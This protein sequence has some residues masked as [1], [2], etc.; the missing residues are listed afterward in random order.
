MYLWSFLK[1]KK[2]KLSMQNL[3]IIS[4]CV[5]MTDIINKYYFFKVRWLGSK[6]NS[7][8]KKNRICNLSKCVVTEHFNYYLFSL[9]WNGIKKNMKTILILWLVNTTK[10]SFNGTVCNDC[11]KK[12]NTKWL[13]G[14]C[15]HTL[16]F[17][18]P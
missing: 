5:N 3:S 8:W 2:T 15:I 10:Y 6:L 9:N 1:Q 16:Q 11:S 12:K 7:I 18:L 4:K 14:N 17:S 13:S